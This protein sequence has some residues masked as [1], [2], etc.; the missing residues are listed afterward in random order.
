[1]PIL[2]II[3]PVYNAGPYIRESIQ[4]ILNQTF[5]DFE[6][7]IID[8][9]ST[10]D[11]VAVVR[12]FTDSRIRLFQNEKNMGIV[13]SRNRGI[14]EMKGRYYAA[15]DADDIAH[16]RKFEIQITYLEKNPDIGMVGCWCYHTDE[17]LKR[18]KSRYKLPGTPESIPVNLLFRAYFVHI[19]VVIRK[20][21]L[22]SGGYTS[23]YEIGEDYKLYVDVTRKFKAWNIPE[24]LV[25]YRRYSKSTT[26][27]N[28]YL[29]ESCEKKIYSFIFKDLNIEINELHFLILKQLKSITPIKSTSELKHI[30]NFLLLIHRKNLE[31]GLF[32]DKLLRKELLNRAIKACYV[33]ETNAF[34]KIFIMLKCI[35]LMLFKKSD[36][37]CF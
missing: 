5:T 24:Y 22:P 26:Q 25:Y 8:D 32:S 30:F 16:P 7:L 20:E 31:L 28:P 27:S 10:D 9:G 18:L 14:Q 4:S 37:P 34:S 11:S 1:M 36:V 15:F 23:G 29:Y 19:S 33:A 35:P 21:A 12:S 17:K 2:S 13:F 6:L 3:I